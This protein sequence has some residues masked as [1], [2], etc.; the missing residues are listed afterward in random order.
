MDPCITIAYCSQ[1]QIHSSTLTEGEPVRF[2]CLL[3]K[4]ETKQKI[5]EHE[6]N[7]KL[8]ELIMSHMDYR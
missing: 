3:H 8:I 7:Q 6:I 2:L 5:K 1:R 4:E